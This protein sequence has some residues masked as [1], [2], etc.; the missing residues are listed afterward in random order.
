MIK[1]IIINLNEKIDV[2]IIIFLIW[3]EKLSSD[4]VTFEG[5]AVT[6]SSK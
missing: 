2:K 5:N 4:K 1:K 6:R 3:T